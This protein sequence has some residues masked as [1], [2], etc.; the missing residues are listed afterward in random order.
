[1]KLFR[2]AFISHGFDASIE[3]V[4]RTINGVCKELLSSEVTQYGSVGLANAKPRYKR[5]SSQATNL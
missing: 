4:R 3:D 1:M 2:E 5:T